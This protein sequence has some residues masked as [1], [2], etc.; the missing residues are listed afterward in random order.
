MYVLRCA[1]LVAGAALTVLPGFGLPHA[2]SMLGASFLLP[3]LAC[4]GVFRRFCLPKPRGLR[5]LRYRVRR[6]LRYT[7]FLTAPFL[8]DALTVMTERM[9]YTAVLP[10]QQAAEYFVWADI[11]RLY[12]NLVGVLYTFEALPEL[13]S[14]RL[15]EQD[16]SARVRM[17]IIAVVATAAALLGLVLYVTAHTN[18]PELVMGQKPVQANVWEISSL[19]LGMLLWAGRIQL[20]GM[21][22]QKSRRVSTHAMLSASCFLIH[23]CILLGAYASSATMQLLYYVPLLSNGLCITGY[24]LTCKVQGKKFGYV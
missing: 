14:E 6:Y 12:V 8:I 23:C 2:L 10:P 24:L 3:V 9:A 5:R 15:L 7:A 13:L 16:A 1:T 21:Y 4:A 18:F 20:L 22:L 19:Y 11:A 17:T